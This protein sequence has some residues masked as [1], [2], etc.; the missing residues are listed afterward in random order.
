MLG[1]DVEWLGSLVSVG[2]FCLAGSFK[3]PVL[4]LMW[5]GLMFTAAN[6]LPAAPVLTLATHSLKGSKPKKEKGRWVKSSF[7][8]NSGHARR[9]KLKDVFFHVEK[10]RN[11]DS[12]G[13]G[14][15][16]VNC[17]RHVFGFQVG[18]K[19]HMPGLAGCL[20]YCSSLCT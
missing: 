6:F 10:S 16:N 20:F 17:E 11:G 5:I 4:Q 8:S 14:M 9:R 18:L 2:C 12:V 15:T 3:E 1:L 13:H 7:R 19:G